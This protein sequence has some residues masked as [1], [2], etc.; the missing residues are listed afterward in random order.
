MNTATAAARIGTQ[1]EALRDSLT[2]V[3]RGK[4]EIVEQAIIAL[5]AGGSILIEDVPGVGKTTLAKALAASLDLDFQ[6]VQCT[7]D[8]LPADIFGYSVF[9][10]RSGSFEFRRGPIYTN[11]L[12][13]DE[14]NRA[15]PRTQSALLE[16][17]AEQQVTVEGIRRA[18]PLPFL[19]LATQNPLG[20][21]GTF[22][23]PESQLDR[24]LFQLC[25]GYPDGESEIEI[26]YGQPSRRP[27][28]ELS[29]VLTRDELLECQAQVDAVKVERCVADYLMRIV[30]R[31]RDD[32][33]LKLGCSPRGALMLFRAAQAAALVRQ[34]DFV[35]PDDVQRVAPLVLPHRLVAA[36]GAQGELAVRRR[37]VEELIQQV[38]VPV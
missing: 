18:L 31:T 32:A 2:S 29:A 34:R 17:M 30:Y 35:L 13:V 24:F 11:L 15:S 16:A 22:P 10:P 38:D 14:I 36:R 4:G 6:R 5:V 8:L 27:L 1:L 21:Q 25:L 26:L 7:P 19:V 12:L 23:L 28:E 3:I 37:I 33:R 20:F 9:D